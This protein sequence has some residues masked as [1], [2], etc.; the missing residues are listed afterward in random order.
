MGLVEKLGP[1]DAAPREVAGAGDFSDTAPNATALAPSWSRELSHL[2]PCRHCGTL[3]GWSARQCWSCE[4]GSWKDL[5]SGSTFGPAADAPKPVAGEGLPLGNGEETVDGEYPV[6]QLSVVAPARPATRAHKRS[7]QIAAAIAVVAL[8]GVAGVVRWG[9]P[10]REAATGNAVQGSNAG[11]A[12]FAVDRASVAP[13]MVSAAEISVGDDPPADA[14]PRDIDAL[15]RVPMQAQPVEP[16]VALPQEAGRP[17]AAIKR[18]PEV[19]PVVAPVRGQPRAQAATTQS[20]RAPSADAAA[21][22]SMPKPDRS[23]PQRPPSPAPAPCTETVAALG[24]C[25]ASSNRSKE[26][27]WTGN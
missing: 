19:A 21:A 6:S 26:F 25:D 27:G 20:G 3:N 7:M 18:P 5:S 11:A 10:F 24:L 16:A 17:A 23:A 15:P 8:A 12:E 1:D 4:A 13:P 9:A 14:A 2:L 22:G